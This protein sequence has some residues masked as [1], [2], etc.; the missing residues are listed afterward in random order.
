ALLQILAR[1]VLDFCQPCLRQASQLEKEL[2]DVRVGEPVGHVQTGLLCLDET[3]PSEHLQMVRGC[4]DALARLVGE[5]FDG[6]W[7]LR[8]E[9][10]KLETA[11]AGG[12]LADACD[13]FVDSVLQGCR[14][15]GHIQIIKLSFEYS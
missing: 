11:W 14:S 10:E 4:R 12:G 9:V 7:P 13:L 5:G 3:H 8:Q 1:D 6:P 2:A 15:G